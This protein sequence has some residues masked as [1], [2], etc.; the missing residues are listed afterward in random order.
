MAPCDERLA[1]LTGFSGTAGLAVVLA[2]R[3]ALFVDGRYTL[4]AAG[5]VMGDLFEVVAVH[6]TP[7][8]RWLEQAAADGM[9]VGYDP[10]LHG[11]AEIDK[12]AEAAARTGARLVA[13]EPNPLDEVW[14]D[15]PPKPMGAVRVHPERLAGEPAAERRRRIGA[16]LAGEGAGEG[17]GNGAGEGADAAVLTQPDSIAWLLN[18]R[19]ADLPH[20]PVALGF[21]VL[22]A[23]GSVALF[24]EPDKLDGEVR[25]HLGNEVAV[26]APDRMEAALAELAGRTVLVDRAA[27]P[28]WIADRLEGAGATL[29]WGEDPCLRPKARKNE[30]ELAG[31]RAAHRR[32]GAA[33][34]RFLHWLD[35]AVAA[36]ETLTEIDVVTRLEEFRAATGALEDIS[37]DT[38]CG[39]GP[40]GAIVHYRVT[41]ETNRTLAPGELLLV[42]SG[43]Q[44]RDGT[45]DITRTI[46]VGPVAAGLRRPFTLVLKGMIA[47]SRARW[48]KGVAGR[49]LD[50]FARAALW[51][52]GLD[53]DHG[54]GHGVGVYL[55]VHEGPARISRRG[56]EVA[57][58]PGMILSNEPG[59]YR[60]GAFGIR[61]ENL[62]AVTGPSVPEGG[63]RPMLG[64]ETLT[65][66]PIDRRLIDS[67]LLGPYD[68]AWLDAYHAR[69]LAEI[70]AELDRED[71]AAVLDWLRRACAPLG[72]GDAAEDAPADAPADGGA[73]AGKAGI[74]AEKFTITPDS[75]YHTVRAAGGILAETRRA[76]I[77]R[78]EGHD[79]VV[80]FPREDVGMEFLER[81]ETRTT[82]P[83]KGA[84]THYDIVGKS[85]VIRDAAWSY[86]DPVEGAAEI[87]GHLAF[88][89]DKV[90][91]EEL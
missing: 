10:W 85:G 43:G 23:D 87:R 79:P 15:R 57:L 73:S 76:L 46:P 6:E 71:D 65:L 53:Y 24:M 86:E 28:L 74:M 3:A 1:W 48:P 32:D 26:A 68:A 5:Q 81:S 78:E 27:C 8:P 33:M 50:T 9:A 44:Y 80:Y 63:E 37:F 41:R 17:S 55:N 88:D 12:L 58:E 13:M 67:D 7:A 38:I 56:G 19:G 75:G 62:V 35:E 59:C 90:T 30:A 2:G 34:A 20:T 64:F 31:A 18:I 11:K 40:N 52:A 70:G 91:V 45:T 60:E 39:A 84:A 69:V 77:L 29:K 82:S 42:D 14:E 16:A 66:A 89:T 36:G 51:Q 22:R 4:Q 61:I 72:A 47:L 21:A 49:D 25:A 83:H 54:T